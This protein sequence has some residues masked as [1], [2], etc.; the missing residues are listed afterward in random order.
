M[1]DPQQ[2]PKAFCGAMTC[3]AI[4]LASMAIVCV[5]TFGY[6]DSG[7]VTAFLLDAYRDDE[8]IVGWLMVANTAVS[9]SVLVTYPLQLF[10][11][12]ELLAPSISRFLP[13]SSGV[14]TTCK[15]CNNIDDD[16]D[17]DNDDDDLS[18]FE[19]LPPLP[20]HERADWGDEDLE[21]HQ[22]EPDV[23]DAA[24]LE[25]TADD[26]SNNNFDDSGSIR[27]ALTSVQSIFP[28]MTMPGDSVGVRLFLV[29]MTYLVAVAVPNVQALISLAGAVAGSSSAL[30]IPPFLELAW[31]QHLEA[32]TAPSTTG[33]KTTTNV[34]GG[35]GFS[36]LRSM[37]S[38]R[39]GHLLN[40]IKCYVLLA[41]GFLFFAIGTYASLADIIRIY[42]G[43]E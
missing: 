8:T 37:I 14:G 40:R 20:E 38:S 36:K 9:I 21:F 39:S 3:V 2:F 35:T 41:L 24:A 26:K 13:C 17:D 42:V 27:S 6:V 34:G 11:A 7:S 22:Y 4:T 5:L 16:N 29:V 18:A 19:P 31:I 10:P 30:L 43:E 32:E 25:S 1:K 15:V 23:D 33:E 28:K 12:I